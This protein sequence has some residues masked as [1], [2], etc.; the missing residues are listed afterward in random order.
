MKTMVSHG[1]ELGVAWEGWSD[2]MH[3]ELVEGRK[4]LESHGKQALS[5][6]GMLKTLEALTSIF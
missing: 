4:R 1:F 2:T 3:F 6:G 5:S